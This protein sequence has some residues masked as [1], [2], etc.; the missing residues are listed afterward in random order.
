MKNKY[1]MKQKVLFTAFMLS[2]FFCFTVKAQAPEPSTEAN[3]KWYFIQVLG[4][5]TRANRVF[6]S[7]N[8]LVVG[9]ERYRTM[10]LTKLDKQLWRLESSG[11]NYA[12]INKSTGK[13]LNV[14][15]NA[16]SKLRVASL[17]NEPSTLWRL[18]KNGSNY[19]IRM[20]TQPSEGTSGEI[21]ATQ[22]N[23]L[24]Y[25]VIFGSSTS[26]ANAR[27][28][29]VAYNDYIPEISTDSKTVW[30]NI[31]TG[32]TGSN[33][34]CITNIANPSD[35]DIKFSIEDVKD[36]NDNQ[37]WK[38]IRKSA[39]ADDERVQLVNKASGRIISPEA[40][41]NEYY[42]AQFTNNMDEGKGWQ[43]NFME[44]G[45]CEI[46]GTAKDGTTRYLNA[47]SANEKPETY[48]PG[49]SE[50]TGF[51]WSFKKAGS[52]TSILEIDN[53]NVIIYSNNKR[54]YVEGA[55]D[56]TIRNIYGVTLS[57]TI[58]LTTGVYLV[59]VKG[60]TTKVLVR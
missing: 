39:E 24:S 23:K 45:Q 32:K 13:K 57:N 34:K 18:I 37:L 19:N 48:I 44:S 17:S 7:D 53:S 21:Y 56:Y 60:K 51:A 47:A 50:N 38:L 14:S 4:E 22:S 2:I 43:I 55:N 54:I 58:D 8:D 40:I 5:D 49:Y 10:D 20:V 28:K 6:T 27:F 16:N 59:T 52:G 33:G 35:P 29:F 11:I 46:Y 15:Y 30:Y 3:P 25:A 31:I 41:Y 12:I 42:Y 26:D 36:N 1:I 9:Q